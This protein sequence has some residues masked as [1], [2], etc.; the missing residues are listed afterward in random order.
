M[1]KIN[2]CYQGF[3]TCYNENNLFYK[4]EN[5]HYLYT[6]EYNILGEI[7][8]PKDRRVKRMLV[9]GIIKDQFLEGEISRL[10][11]LLL[12]VRPNDEDDTLYWYVEKESSYRLTILKEI[13]VN[14]SN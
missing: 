5:R 3:S 11:L 8:P 2:H 14:G 12:G 1:T 4:Q 9:L 13:K 7:P 10:R 6:T